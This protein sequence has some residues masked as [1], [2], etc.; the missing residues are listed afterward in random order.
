[1]TE[2]S[3]RCELTA[4]IHDLEKR[5]R[6][7]ERARDHFLAFV[8]AWVSA[9]REKREGVR[10]E[11][12]KSWDG[13][14]QRGRQVGKRIC[15]EVMA[16]RSEAAG[17][18]GQAESGKSMKKEAAASEAYAEHLQPLSESI[19]DDAVGSISD[20]LRPS[21]QCLAVSGLALEA[22]AAP[23]CVEAMAS[24][25]STAHAPRP[26]Q[27]H[28]HAHVSIVMNVLCAS[29]LTSSTHVNRLLMRS[30]ANELRCTSTLNNDGSSRLERGEHIKI[31]RS[32]DTFRFRAASR[33]IE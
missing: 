31:L 18:T 3:G 25:P 27:V 30:R 11:K 22:P 28:L 2:L 4:F 1:M 8:R 32:F 16:T 14:Q 20:R 23:R 19:S 24:P 33:L 10:E 17:R 5:S 12:G 6:R 7:C 29:K 9:D 15:T 26:Q 13:K 21:A